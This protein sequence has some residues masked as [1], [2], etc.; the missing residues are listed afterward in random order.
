[1]HGARRL[2]ASVVIGRA[3]AHQRFKLGAAK[4]CRGQPNRRIEQMGRARESGR[5]ER[6]SPATTDLP[7]TMRLAELPESCDWLQSA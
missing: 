2:E 5:G 3:S 1:V 6:H 4:P 7:I